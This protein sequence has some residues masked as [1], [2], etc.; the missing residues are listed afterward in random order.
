MEWEET[1]REGSSY[2]YR[3]QRLPLVSKALGEGP[4]ALGEAFSECNTRGRAPGYLFTGK[5]SSPR[6]KNRALGEGFL[7][8]RSGTRGR[9]DAI[10]GS[11]R[12]FLLKKNLPRVQH[13]GK[14][15]S[16][17]R[18]AVQTLG[19]HTLFPESRSTDTRGRHPLPWEPQPRHSGKTPS[20]PRAT[21]QALGE[22]ALFPESRSQG[23]RG[24]NS[25]PECR[26][27]CTRGSHFENYFF[28]FFV[29]LCKQQS[30]YISQ[31]KNQQ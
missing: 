27:P 2:H 16:S 14:T 17:P 6:A 31:I 10:G 12:H 21:A 23:T 28:L 18:A 30:I 8:S 3:K 22:D 13:S 1:I 11:R 19:E 7:E 24:R 29:L 20:S 26:S 4:V 25:L 15:L 5:T 9:V